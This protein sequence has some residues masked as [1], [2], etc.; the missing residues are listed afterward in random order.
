VNGQGPWRDS[1]CKVPSDFNAQFLVTWRNVEATLREGGM[2][3]T[4][5]VKVTTLMASREYREVYARIREQVPGTHRCALTIVIRDIYAPEW[6]LEI[7]AIA[8]R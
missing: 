3:L 5:L 1:N 8:A 4:D 7:E 2:Q 6:L